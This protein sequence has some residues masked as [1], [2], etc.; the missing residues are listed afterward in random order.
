MFYSEDNSTVYSGEWS[1]GLR[2]GYGQMKYSSGNTYEG[3]WC[4]D[5]KCGRGV[6]NWRHSDELYT[7]DWMDDHPHGFGEHIWGGRDH[8]IAG[9]QVCNIYRGDWHYGARQG[10]GTF[11]YANGSQYSGNCTNIFR[12]FLLFSSFFSFDE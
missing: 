11:F 9:K 4:L 12:P 1:L 10:Q 3:E 7:G 6:M 5:K 8:K 2:E